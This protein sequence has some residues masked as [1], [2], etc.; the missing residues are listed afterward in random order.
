M[1]KDSEQERIARI[2]EMFA[3]LSK[4]NF[5]F[6]IAVTGRQD[7]LD[8]LTIYL[9]LFAAELEAFLAQQTTTPHASS[10]PA[11]RHKDAALINQVSDYILLHLEEPLPTLKTLSR[12]FYTNERKLKDGFR[13]LFQT[14]IYK[15]YNEERLKRAEGL[16]LTTDIP[17]NH[18]APMCGFNTYHNFSTAFKKHFGYAPIRLRQRAI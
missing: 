8:S 13:E 14:S 4:G 3:E 12:M 5:S 16:I 17:L 10:L 11:Y 15:F 6:R 1:P 7:Y 2:H 9:N 18:I